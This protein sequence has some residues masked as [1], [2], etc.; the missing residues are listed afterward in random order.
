V[1]ATAASVQLEANPQALLLSSR[2]MQAQ[3][4]AAGCGFSQRLLAMN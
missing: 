2:M 1:V 3:A 4:F